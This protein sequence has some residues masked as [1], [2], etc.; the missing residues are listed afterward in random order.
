MQQVGEDGSTPGPP[1]RALRVQGASRLAVATTTLALVALAS[2]GTGLFVSHITREA[3]G[4]PTS[5]GS[6][7]EPS[8][9]GPHNIVVDRAPG[10][11]GVGWS[12]PSAASRAPADARA[13]SPLFLRGPVAAPAQ[14]GALTL[15]GA[16]RQRPSMPVAG[17]PAADAHVV[18]V[19][20]VVTAATPDP[21]GQDSGSAHQNR[22]K[23]SGGCGS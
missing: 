7:A 23:N 3:M 13:V 6:T 12:V 10:T 19:A 21:P 18:A 15:S 22:G 5:P 8:A 16:S 11:W 14:S 2:T 17:P 1:H 9:V 20:H 4:P